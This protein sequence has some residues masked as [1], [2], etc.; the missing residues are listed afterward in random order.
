MTSWLPAFA[1]MTYGFGDI[2]GITPIGHNIMPA[3]H[4]GLMF[5]FIRKKFV[6]SYFFLSSSSLLYVAP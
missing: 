6:G 5:W 1:G 2:N 4:T 3:S